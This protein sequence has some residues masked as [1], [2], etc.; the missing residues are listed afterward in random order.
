MELVLSTGQKLSR[1]VQFNTEHKIQGRRPDVII[2][3][4]IIESPDTKEF[5][6]LVC[7]WYDECKLIGARV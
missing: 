2:Y 5:R 6:D 1:E 7:K 4:D 3:D